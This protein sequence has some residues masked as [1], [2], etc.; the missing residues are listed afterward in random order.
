MSNAQRARTPSGEGRAAGTPSVR[1]LVVA[2]CWMLLV[3]P[4]NGATAWLAFGLIAAIGRRRSWWV[5]AVV[6]AVVALVLDEVGHPVG[7]I[8]QGTL[9]IVIIAHALLVNPVWLS[10][11][12]ARR[13]QGLTVFGNQR[14]ARDRRSR[15]TRSNADPVPPEAEKLL[16]GAG[17]S[18]SDYLDDGA[19]A[20]G[21]RPARSSRS[22]RS[23]RAPAAPAAPPAPVEPIDVNTANQRVL[24]RLTGMD[25]R[26]AKTVIAE[27]TKRGGFGSLEDFA[28]SAGLQPHEIV[29]LRDEAF[30]SPRPRAARSF[31]RRVD[32]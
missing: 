32:F 2:S 3:L 29:R 6:Y 17:A 23:S 14:N 18:R 12:W 31:G 28:S 30:C 4:P 21:A 27:R 9:S 20:A 1:W 16:G 26:L 22:R 8:L 13:E 7:D 11:L 25:R 15:A 24:A 19:D 10:D 5:A